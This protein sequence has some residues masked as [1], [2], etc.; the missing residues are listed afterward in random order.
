MKPLSRFLLLFLALTTMA[1][2][3]VQIHADTGDQRPVAQA[4]NN[5]QKKT[6]SV[7]RNVRAIGA[8]VAALAG[9]SLAS[10][11]YVACVSK[12]FAVI[13]AVVAMSGT[14]AAYTGISNVVNNPIVK[15]VLWMAKKVVT[16]PVWLVK[17]VLGFKNEEKQDTKP[18]WH[19]NKVVKAGALLAVGLLTYSAI[20]ARSSIFLPLVA[21]GLVYKP[22]TVLRSTWK[23]IQFV[24]GQG[25]RVTKAGISEAWIGIKEGT[26]QLFGK[27]ELPTNP[28][29]S[30]RA[31]VVHNRN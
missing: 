22:R 4:E 2:P 21:A 13:G 7:P 8:G 12:L 19:K 31:Q 17:L 26:K 1:A 27:T 28:A 18:A 9:F 20:S 30:G 29:S 24:A 25:K 5:K 16:F 6:F 23:G 15:P 3:V 14:Y 11:P 10:N